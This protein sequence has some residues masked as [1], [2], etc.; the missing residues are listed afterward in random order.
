[1]QPACGQTARRRTR[2]G[3]VLAAL[4]SGRDGLDARPARRRARKP[5]PHGT[6][7]IATT[8]A[9]WSSTSSRAG[10]TRRSRR[11]SAGASAETRIDRPARRAAQARDVHERIRVA[12]SRGRRG[13]TR[14][15]PDDV[16]VVHDDVDLEFGRLQARSG[17]VSP[18]TTG[19]GR[20][21]GGSAARSS[22]GSGSGSGVRGAVTRATSPTSSSRRSRPRVDD[23]HRR[24]RGRRSRADPSRRAGR[25]AAPLQLTRFVPAIDGARPGA[26]IFA[27]FVHHL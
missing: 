16:L 27:T 15:P 25:G 11:S 19:C 3:V 23:E 18:A 17:A 13:S 9:G 21:P 12:R 1:M 6:S 5:G 20:S 14:S 2:R 26:L 24:A 4:P 10:T 8:S 7:A 22:C